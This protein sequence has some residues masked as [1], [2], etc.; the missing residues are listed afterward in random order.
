MSKK[1]LRDQ[2][3][4]V[5]HDRAT[6][7]RREAELKTIPLSEV[8]KVMKEEHGQSWKIPFVQFLTCVYGYD[9]KVAVAI[10]EYEEQNNP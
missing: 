6:L 4:Q 7:Q 5:Y 3:L 10:R 2:A 9:L 8:M 1:H